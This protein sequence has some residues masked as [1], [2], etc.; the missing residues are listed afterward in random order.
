MSRQIMLKTLR[1]F[2]PTL[3]AL[4]QY[5]FLTNAYAQNNAVNTGFPKSSELVY[6]VLAAEIALQRGQIGAAYQTYMAI[7]KSSQDPK[8]AQRA[9][10]IALAGQSAQFSLEAAELWDNLANGK[11]K[12]AREVRITLLMLNNRWSEA[13]DPAINHLRALKPKQK[14]PFLLECAA[15][16]AKSGNDDEAI[17]AF[18]KIVS[19]MPELPKN[20]DLLFLYSMGEEKEKRFTPMENALKAIIK[21]DPNHKN[22]LNALGYSWADRNIKLKEAFALISRAHKLSPDD[23][24]IL[25]SLGWVNFRLD[26]LDLAAD[27]LQRAFDMKPEAEIGAHLGEVLWSLNKRAEAEVIWKK[28]ETIDANNAS[29]KE[30]LRR[31]KVDWALPEQFDHTINRRWD[32]RFAVKINGKNNQD[33]GSGSFSLDH[34]A[35]NDTLELRGPMGVAFAKITVT[36]AGATLEQGGKISEAI[37]ADTLVKEAIGMP[38]PARGLSAWLAGYVRPGSPGSV[39][40]NEKGNVSKII[41]D[42]WTLN[43]VWNKKNKLEKLNLERKSE[44]GDVDIRLVFD[45]VDD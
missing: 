39:E 12:T 14:E 34:V 38:I 35:L 36:A 26:K 40:R 43:Y 42:G 25:D 33:G 10:E 7:A 9:M 20:N 16:I 37:D 31:L 15:M 4:C 11:D 18:A 3:F 19:S 45:S 21:N 23:A 6:Q 41:Q 17:R 22:A 5:C 2:A 29:L 1:F 28:A 27:Q 44:M 8:A 24:F 30:T 13:V 32:G